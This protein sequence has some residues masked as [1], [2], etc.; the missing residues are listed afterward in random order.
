MVSLEQPSTSLMF[1]TLLASLR[2]RWLTRPCSWLHRTRPHRVTKA[3]LPSLSTR[4]GRGDGT[5]R[6][7]D[8]PLPTD[9]TTLRRVALV[10]EEHGVPCLPKGAS[11]RH[12][13]RKRDSMKT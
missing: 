5:A 9:A 6:N 1:R 4:H 12:D 13:P 3:G 8:I 11:A 7:V 10:A 2:H